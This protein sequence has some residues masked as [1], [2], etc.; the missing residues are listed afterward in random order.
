MTAQYNRALKLVLGEPSGKGIDLS[1]LRVSFRVQHFDTQTP[2]SLSAR[3]YNLSQRTIAAAPKEGGQVLLAAGYHGLGMPD[4]SSASPVAVIFRGKITQVRVGRESQTDTYLDVFAA[5]GDD[6]HNQ[7]TVNFTLAAGATA[8]EVQDAI[9]NNSLAAYGI[10][11][12]NAPPL[13]PVA[14]PRGQ[15]FYGMA[16]DHLRVLARD[17]ACTW[18]FDDGRLDFTPHTQALPGPAIV[19]TSATG[20]VG[21]PQQTEDGIAVR[22]LLNPQ[23]RKGGLV[24][25]NNASIQRARYSQ[26]S[27]SGNTHGELLPGIDNQGG[28]NTSSDG[29]YKVIWVDYSGDTRGQEWYCDLMCLTAD[30]SGFIPPSVANTGGL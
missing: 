10:T 22:C 1:A 5:D 7:A 9:L 27:T 21:L 11:K 23:I 12:G 17:N 25:I 26:N 6:V 3:V 8:A 30:G 4:A 16:R 24:R 28:V 15:V 19:L 14:L 2:K 13:S 18:G 29:T 20:M